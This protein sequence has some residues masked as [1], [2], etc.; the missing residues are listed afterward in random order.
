M[1]PVTSGGGWKAIGYTL[2]MANRVGWLRL[3]RA[4][5]SKNSCKTCALG[6][7]GQAGGMVNEGG[8]FPEVC[9]KSLQAMTS[10]MQA[11]ITPEFWRRFGFN[12]LRAMSPRQLE[13]CG[14]LVEPVYAAPGD[15]Q[16]RPISWNE[17]FSRL[18]DKLQ[19]AGPGRSFFYASGR[20]SNE[21]G[22]LLQLF[23]RLFG[24]NYVNNCSYYCHQA[25]GVGLTSAVGTGTGTITLEDLDGCDLY[26]LIGGNPAS[27]HPRLMRSLMQIRRRGG[28]VIVVNPVRE[29]GLVNF[30]VPSDVRSL[31]FGTRIASQYIQPHIGGDIALLTGVAK[32]VLERGGANREFI[33][34]ATEGFDDFRQQVEATAWDEI[35]RASGV[36]RD[37]IASFADRYLAAKNV[38]FGWT[39]GI[40]HHRHGVENV[41]MIANLAL[42]R[43]MVG[44]PHAGFMPIRG[45]SN[46]QGVGSVGVTPHLKQALLERF[47]S[48]LGVTVPKSPG[49]DTMGCMQAADRGEMRTALCLGGNLFGSN[50]DAAFAARAIGKLDAITYL[51][52]TLNTTH[53]WGR[54]AETLILPVFPRDE[55][56]QPTTQESMFSFV[57]LSDGGPRRYAGPRSEVSVLLE[58]AR[59]ILG[60]GGRVD[61]QSLES[62]AAIRR[63]IADLIPSLEPLS[64]IDATKREF[65]IAGRALHTPRFPTAS[66]KARFHAVSIPRLPTVGENQ[67]RL[68][69]IRSEGQ[70]NTVV[71]EDEDLYRGQERRDV[72]LMNADDIFRLGLH[73][74][75]LVTVRSDVSEMRRQIVRP[76]GIRPGNAAMYCP[77]ANVLVPAEVDPL[78]KTPAFKS[79]LVR[80]CPDR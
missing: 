46:V 47:E 59:R 30:R 74:D 39:M 22:F 5:R 3:W 33:E 16:Y 75:Q 70:F 72:I 79:V 24:T 36:S 48:R 50:P 15:T 25:S 9:K 57:R 4:M 11:G 63:L 29:V 61:W 32:L 52:T 23:A 20:S 49:L 78:S 26:V 19:G 66:G 43:G 64:Q 68:M 2:R 51:S 40:T 28:D 12:E 53:A 14:R 76:I 38:I 21:A 69:T 77:E 34:S 67:L 10:D 55:E 17:A 42:L 62:H 31:L 35:E 18:S 45:H 65:H 80:I 71:Y 7:G 73:P 6:M 27:N 60:D 54:A 41:R 1:R 13:A 8:H 56:S 44:K 37:E 58:I